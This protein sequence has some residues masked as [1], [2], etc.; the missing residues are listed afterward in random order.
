MPT[1]QAQARTATT[2]KGYQMVPVQGPSEGVDLRLSQ[3]LLPAGRA[4]TLVNWSLEEPG[5]LVIAKGYRR[6]S[7]GALGTERIQGAQRVYLNTAVPNPASTIVTLV[8]RNGG[9]Y[10]QGDTGGWAS[11]TPY[12]TGLS[13]NEVYFTADRDLVAAFDGSTG[14]AFKSTNGSSWTA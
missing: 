1:H 2:T 10:V 9:L 14:R 8:A 5:A 4:R 6:F 13:T 3:T 11:T 12:L 7:T